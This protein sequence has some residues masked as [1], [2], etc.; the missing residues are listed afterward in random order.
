MLVIGSLS[1][2][3]CQGFNN[4]QSRNFCLC[5]TQWQVSRSFNLAGSHSSVAVGGWSN[6]PRMSAKMH[7]SGYICLHSLMHTRLFSTLVV[8]GHA[9]TARPGAR[10]GRAFSRN[11]TSAISREN[12]HHCVLVQHQK[13]KLSGMLALCAFSARRL[14][15]SAL[16]VGLFSI[17]AA[18]SA[19]TRK[20]P[21]DACSA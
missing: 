5:C 15:C 14:A 21:A 10:L 7:L 20:T 17:Q 13:G 11:R 18:C 16:R 6:M 3:N 19:L 4:S 2:S 1:Q 8:A 12:S 9:W